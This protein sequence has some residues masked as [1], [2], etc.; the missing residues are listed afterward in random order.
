MRDEE[1]ARQRQRQR[2]SGEWSSLGQ[3]CEHG[4]A[5]G[6]R[7]FLFDGWLDRAAD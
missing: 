3:C 7:D 4:I 5:L 6:R 2:Q 1:P